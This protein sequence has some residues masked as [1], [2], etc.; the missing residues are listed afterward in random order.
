MIATPLQ[1][2]QESMNTSNVDNG[3]PR[4]SGWRV[5]GGTP[6]KGS[7]NSG[8]NVSAA[9]DESAGTVSSASKDCCVWVSGASTG[10]AAVIDAA[11][12]GGGFASTTSV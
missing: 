1:S 5:V 7:V 2:P 6:D 11:D 12:D 3:S 9:A 4:I 8:G 10:P